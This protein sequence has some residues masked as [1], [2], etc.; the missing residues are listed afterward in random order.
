M[1]LLP[2]L[3]SFSP[4]WCFGAKGGEGSRVLFLVGFRVSHKSH[5]LCLFVLIDLCTRLLDLVLC[6]TSLWFFGV[7]SGQALIYA[8]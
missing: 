7:M 4:F 3:L 2:Y 8:W 5:I 1:I 6:W